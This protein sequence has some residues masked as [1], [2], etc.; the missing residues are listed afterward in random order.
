[1]IPEEL[2]QQI[3]SELSYHDAWALKQTSRLFA[4]VV[5]IP[6][7]KS[8]LLLP[9]GKALFI[10]RESE[11]IPFSHELCCYCRRLLHF[12]CYGREKRRE[13]TLRRASLNYEEWDFKN[14]FCLECG[15]AHMKY[16]P[17]QR[18]LTGFGEAGSKN[19]AVV[20]CWHC[21]TLTDFKYRTC[22]A[23]SLPWSGSMG[24][25]TSQSGYVYVGD[26]GEISV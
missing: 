8:F 21:G 4:R 23:C 20:S 24:K 26:M 15:V 22:E 7:V 2:R 1:M 18:I 6:T 11:V 14:Q 25:K 9:E 5:Q 12:S 17:G 16:M 3:I 10:L 19:E 13:F